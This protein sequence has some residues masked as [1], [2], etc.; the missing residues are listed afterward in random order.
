VTAV[1]AHIYLGFYAIEHGR[2]L[3]YFAVLGA[4]NAIDSVWNIYKKYRE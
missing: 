3:E 2:A 4:T 1:P